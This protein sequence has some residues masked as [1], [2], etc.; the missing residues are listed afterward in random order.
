M[1]ASKS[2]SPWVMCH[3]PPCW[4]VNAMSDPIVLP[5]RNRHETPKTILLPSLR[6]LFIA[7]VP[8]A[9]VIC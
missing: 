1:S 6:L 8:P 3:A 2:P 7:Q 4:G 5:L 9:Y